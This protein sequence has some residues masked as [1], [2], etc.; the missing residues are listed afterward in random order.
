MLYIV[1]T[2]ALNQARRHAARDYW[3]IFE[4]VG[5]RDMFLILH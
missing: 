4:I 2:D 3:L 5:P 1:V